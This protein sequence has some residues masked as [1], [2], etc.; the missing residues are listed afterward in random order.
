M[1]A[2]SNLAVDPSLK[3]WL[4]TWHKSLQDVVSQTAGHPVIFESSEVAWTHSES[5]LCFVIV[6]SGAARGEMTLRIAAPGA[7][8]LAQLGMREPVAGADLAAESREAVEGLL[9]QVTARAAASTS[10]PGGEIQLQLTS[11]SAPS[12]PAAAALTLQDTGNPS[13]IAVE[14]KISAALAAALRPASDSTPSS[15][16]MSSYDRFLDVPL[17]VKIRFGSRRMLLR[18]VL[19]LSTGAVLELDRN[20]Q[21]AVDLILDGRVIAQGEVVVVDGKYGLRVTSVFEQTTLA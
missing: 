8:Q 14:I 1:T 10:H 21:S 9:R 5:D 4:E 20:L 3:S 15:A 12:W 16:V 17:E 2:T 6:A 7:V 18:E 13:P 19:A 11:S